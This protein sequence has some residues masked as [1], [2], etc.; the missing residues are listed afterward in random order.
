MNADARRIL[1]VFPRRTSMTPTDEFAFVGDPPLWRPEADEVDV[2]VTF[3]W[4][5]AEGQRLQR[6]WSLYYPIVRLGGPAFDDAGGEF[7]AGRYLRDGVTITTRGCPRACD[8]CMVPRREGK[9][10]LLQEI[11]P[12]NVV[13]DNNLL[14]APREHWDRVT[15]MLETQRGIE[16][17][18]GLDVQLIRPWHSDWIIAQRRHIRHVFFA[19][20][21]LNQLPALRQ[22]VT[23]LSAGG[24]RRRQLRCYVLVGYQGDTIDAA[25]ERLEEAWAAGTLPFAMR[26]RG[27][28]GK[29]RIEEDWYR[30]CNKWMRPAATFASR[31]EAEDAQLMVREDAVRGLY[32]QSGWE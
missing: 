8:Y 21:R 7:V 19:Y 13:Q 24:M 17:S 1:R 16:F 25:A 5:R 20:D 32:E 31:E 22:V 29:R 6:A 4:D 18:G 11:G 28:D 14:A 12:G 23:R 10:R 3:T 2:S 9:L 27:V 15:T 30:L 26:W